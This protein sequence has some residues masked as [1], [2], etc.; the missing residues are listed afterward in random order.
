[1]LDFQFQ[2]KFIQN[3]TYIEALASMPFDP[4][5]EHLYY[6]E[7]RKAGAASGLLYFTSFL[8]QNG[9][10]GMLSWAKQGLY[11]LLYGKKNPQTGMPV[12]WHCTP[13]DAKVFMDALQRYLCICTL[14]EHDAMIKQIS[15]QFNTQAPQFLLDAISRNVTAASVPD[16]NAI[17]TLAYLYVLENAALVADRAV[18][19][20]DGNLNGYEPCLLT[21]NMQALQSMAQAGAFSKA[22][23]QA[24]RVS[25]NMAA[26][27][28]AK[29][30]IVGDPD[31]PFGKKTANALAKGELISVKLVAKSGMIAPYY[32]LTVSSKSLDV[33]KNERVLPLRLMYRYM[34]GLLYTVAQTPYIRCETSL[35]DGSVVPVDFTVLPNAY[36]E[37]YKDCNQ[38]MI[39]QH[40]AQRPIGF[41][42]RYCALCVMS[43]TSSIYSSGRYSK[44]NPYN[45]RSISPIGLEQIDRSLHN[46]DPSAIYSVFQTYLPNRP[47]G[48]YAVIIDSLPALKAAYDKSDQGTPKDMQFILDNLQHVHYSDIYRLMKSAPK[49]F[50]S[51]E[52]KLEVA[53]KR[54]E[55]K[56]IYLSGT[57][58]Q[59][60]AT[61]LR[62]LMSESV[63]LISCMTANGAYEVY[64]TSNEEL[65]AKRFG[66]AYKMRY[67][68][69]DV[70]CEELKKYILNTQGI[71][72]SKVGN[73]I[74]TNG[75]RYLDAS[76]LTAC[77]EASIDKW[78]SDARAA[79]GNRIGNRA[80][81]ENLLLVRNYNASGP[82]EFW[83]NIDINSIRYIS[84]EK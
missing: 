47:A 14:A 20:R 38:P 45:V 5:L 36:I 80:T 42:P 67:E 79:A 48:A 40:R 60:K 62:Q 63:V 72:P 33:T 4:Q 51:F 71:T 15:A 57:T 10:Q 43:V 83:K 50:P 73:L 61:Q 82:D 31:M 76:K 19:S 41:T 29:Q 84:V 37:A 21:R 7:G 39:V 35:L 53:G 44:I 75:I 16:T 6:D 32:E 24:T 59:E 27:E 3:D 70:R 17:A 1:M 52:S 66:S 49:F 58:V 77:D 30:G 64:T 9:A 25:E 55:L 28:K 34:E 26:L 56:D 13:K 54:A 12:L 68:A 78:I 46:V 23:D 11:S 74:Q 18:Y 2:T 22:T 81:S 8:R 69:W 65:L